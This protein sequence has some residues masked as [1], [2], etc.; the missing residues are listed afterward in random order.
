MTTKKTPARDMAGELLR[1]T[2]GTRKTAT[3]APAPA[4]KSKASPLADDLA[5]QR[6]MTL[7]QIPITA[8][9]V[10][11]SAGGMV[12]R[13]M[14]FSVAEWRAVTVRALATESA[15]AEVVRACVRQALGL[16]DK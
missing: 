13:S 3:T 16:P 6:S 4:R 11:R 12:R 7:D 1:P 8:S 9:A 10:S 5:A 15:K 2:T 14:Y